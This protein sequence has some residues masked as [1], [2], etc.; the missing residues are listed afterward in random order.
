[1]GNHTVVK[2]SIKRYEKRVDK[3]PSQNSLKLWGI[4]TP[5]QTQESV[6]PIQTID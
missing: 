6:L 2:K 1:M 5:I 3:E 4:E